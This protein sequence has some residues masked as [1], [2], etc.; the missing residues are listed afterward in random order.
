M[1]S[2]GMAIANMLW[3]TRSMQRYSLSDWFHDELIEVCDFLKNP[4]RLPA[5]LVIHNKM[6]GQPQ[7][8]E[9]NVAPNW[10]IG[11]HFWPVEDI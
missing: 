9:E 5:E 2:V 11:L 4:I 10:K 1:C 7:L 6:G 3:Y 8:A